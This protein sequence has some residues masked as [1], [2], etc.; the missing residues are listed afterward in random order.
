MI[1]Y[2]MITRVVVSRPRMKTFS[3]RHPHRRVVAVP[4]VNHVDFTAVTVVG[5]P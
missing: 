4:L 1:K 5:A 2:V 3:T